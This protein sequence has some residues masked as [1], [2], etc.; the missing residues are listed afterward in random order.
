[1]TGVET[2]AT[3]VKVGVAVISRA[4]PTGLEIVKAW[5]KGKEVIIVGQARAGKTTFVDYLQFGLFEDEKDTSK[6]RDV[7]E[8]ARFN[9]KMGR[10]SALQLSVKKVV[11]V[12]G[13]IGAAWQ[14]DEVFYRRPHAIVIMT[15]L[16]SPLDGEPDR[17]AA[18]WLLEFCRELESNWRIKGKRGNRVKSIILVMNKLDKVTEDVVTSR[19]T[20]FQ[21]ILNTELREAR[22][23][24]LSEIAIMPCSLVTNPQGTK[25]VDAVIAHLAKT[26]ARK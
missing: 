10:D 11:D 16:T 12:P 20:K 19:K 17:A 23:R 1:M 26:L 8:S 15:D 6:T 7:E 9:I 18:A 25:A 3:L 22:G 14:A 5:L 24:M 21:G 2:S 4:A 13:Q